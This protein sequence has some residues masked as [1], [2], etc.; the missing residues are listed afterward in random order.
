MNPSYLNKTAIVA[1]MLTMLMTGAMGDTV[2][3]YYTAPP[4]NNAQGAEENLRAGVTNNDIE[5]VKAAIKA[6]VNV[7]AV[8]M[9]DWQNMKSTPLIIATEK[10]Y[11]EIVKALIAAGADVNAKNEY[12]RTA[13]LQAA[14]KK[15]RGK[16]AYL[17]VK[18]GADVNT[19]AN[20][21]RSALSMAASYS[22]IGVMKALVMG[23]VDIDK[24]DD[25]LTP[26]FYAIRDNREKSVRFL[27]K[28]GADIKNCKKVMSI[29]HSVEVANA[30]LKAGADINEDNGAPLTNSIYY[31]HPELFEFLIKSGAKKTPEILAECLNSAIHSNNP[32]TVSL[33]LQYEADVNFA[34]KNTGNTPLMDGVKKGNAKIVKILL[35][36]GADVDAKNKNGETALSLAEKLTKNKEEIIKLLSEAKK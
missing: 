25:G 27:L 35:E 22:H 30:L 13:L 29:A 28:H 19:K 21:G 33:V 26:L 4:A 2:Q 15:D 14:C 1:S 20:G 5:K 3:N 31:G 23:K 18:A 10:G 6:G 32:N 36:A 17:L 11:E 16:I 12:G 9:R 34:N 24:P 8:E 7:N